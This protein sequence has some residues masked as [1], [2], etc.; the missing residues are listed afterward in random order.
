MT[1]GLP[2]QDDGEAHEAREQDVP[3]DQ[4]L[5]VDGASLLA[6]GRE[7]GAG[8]VLGVEDLKVEHLDRGRGHGVDPRFGI[9]EVFPGEHHHCEADDGHDQEGMVFLHF[10]T[11][12][13]EVE[14]GVQI[15]PF[16]PFFVNL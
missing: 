10:S 1:E 12:P 8:V 9:A 4:R 2:Q 7:R 6:H 16:S 13:G 11:L 14:P 5:P 15:L 3:V